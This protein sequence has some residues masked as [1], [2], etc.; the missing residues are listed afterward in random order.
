MSYQSAILRYLDPGEAL[1]EALFGLIMALT[2]SVGA[3]IVTSVGE[4]N[5]RA[6]I[7]TAIGCNVAWGVIDATLFVFGGL[8]H[9]SQR[10]RFFR[11]LKSARSEEE[12]LDAI[13]EEFA[14]EDE[15]L[16]V[17]RED[18]ARLQRSIL[19]LSVHAAPRSV[20][21]RRRDLVPAFF[22]FALVA[23][24]GLPGV[25]PFLLVDDFDLAL[26][27][28]NIVLVSLLFI[29][30]FWWGHYTDV[31]PWIVGVTVMLLGLSMVFVAVALG[32]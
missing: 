27:L 30:G 8:F 25:V 6:L 17:V 5:P 12:A 13:R 1:G 18:H 32:G 7:L 22:V 26:G 21:L 4:P 19:A 29:V 11:V 23:F 15:P 3:R 31:R 10:A 24:T 2:F 20:H 14:L 9:R 16:S 28:S